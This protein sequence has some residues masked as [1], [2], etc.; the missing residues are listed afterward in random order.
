[1]ASSPHQQTDA[2][3]GDCDDCGFRASGA[4]AFVRRKA[5]MHIKRTGHRLL[6]SQQ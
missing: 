3:V 5:S 2:Y 1:M 4:E 6:V